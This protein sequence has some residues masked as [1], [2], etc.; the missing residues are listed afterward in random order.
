MFKRRKKPFRVVQILWFDFDN[1][2][3]GKKKSRFTI[4]LCLNL[5]V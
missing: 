5:F 1:K 2:P 3:N 4:L